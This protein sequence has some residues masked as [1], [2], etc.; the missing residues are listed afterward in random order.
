MLGDDALIMSHR[1][2][3]WV[4]N[5]PELEDEVALANIGLD[6]I[7]QARL[8]YTRAGKADGTDRNEDLFAFFRDEGEFRNVRL[9]ETPNGDFA[10]SMA[11]LLAFA[12]WRLALLH[13]LTA[14]GDAV[15]AAIAV[16]GVKE[17]TYHRDYAANWVVRLGDGTELSHER[18]QSGLDGVW[19]LVDELFDT[20]PIEAELAGVAVDPATLRAEFDEVLTQVIDAATLTRPE[21]AALGGVAG[22]TGRDGVHT[23]SFGFIVAELQS[24][25]RAN[26]EASW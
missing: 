5:A 2:Q 21:A 18:M 26:P 12:T 10:Y 15:L 17:V 20:H 16:K 24:V 8:L 23:E 14:S 4:T 22:R 1:L 25:A 9:V 6:L 11:R 19:P 13:R 7:G 3:E